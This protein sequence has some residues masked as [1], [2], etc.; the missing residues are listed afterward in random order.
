MHSREG[1]CEGGKAR[2]QAPIYQCACGVRRKGA[3][4]IIELIF[5]RLNIPLEE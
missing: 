1:V 5:E 3:K 2:V 4:D